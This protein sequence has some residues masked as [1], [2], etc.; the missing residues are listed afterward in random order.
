LRPI[1]VEL[2]NMPVERIAEELTRRK[3][4]TARGGRWHG[5]RRQGCSIG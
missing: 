2:R 5:G 3:V 4:A 1:L